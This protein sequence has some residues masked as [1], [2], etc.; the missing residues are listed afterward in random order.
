MH[1]TAAV[2]KNSKK[3]KKIPSLSK[4]K[5]LEKDLRSKETVIGLKQ[6]EIEER[7]GEISSLQIKLDSAVRQAKERSELF[8][9]MQ[10]ELGRENDGLNQENAS[11]Q[12][13]QKI[14]ELQMAELK[15]ATG[16]ASFEAR[17][18]E[19]FGR[20][21]DK[22]KMEI[23]DLKENI[24]KMSED[25]ETRKRYDAEITAMYGGA[26]KEMVKKNEMLDN[27]KNI[28]DKFLLSLSSKLFFFNYKAK[29]AMK[30]FRK[31]YMYIKEKT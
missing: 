21:M 29:W 9:K 17:I 23:R 1:K 24:R 11:L 18:N 26:V 22:H 15:E 30:D 2:A 25:L 27:L 14:L 4:F 7:K 16:V 20:L 12:E 31:R 3:S 10:G 28:V 19:D 5:D 8:E 6:R 13:R